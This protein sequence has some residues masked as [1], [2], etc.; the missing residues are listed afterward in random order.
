[1]AGFTMTGMPARSAGAIFS[2]IPQTGKL[3]AL[4]CTATPRSGTATWRPRKVPRRESRSTPPSRKTSPSG[5]S[6]RPLEA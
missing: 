5:I 2:S 6:R 3:K 4:I 1:M